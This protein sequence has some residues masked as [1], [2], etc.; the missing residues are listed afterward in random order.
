MSLKITD[1]ERTTLCVPFTPRCEKWN[2]REVWN[3]K[4]VEICRVETDAGFVGWGETL[5]HY[6]W[7]KVSDSSVD[8][9]LGKNPADFLGDD[10]LGAGLQM[11]LY[12]VVGKALGV[13]V[14]R[15]LN[16]PRVR[17]WCPISWWTIDFPPEALAEEAKDALAA[18]YVAYKTKA[19]PSFYCF[20][21]IDSLRP[22]SP[23]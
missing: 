18:G 17:E 2:A 1:V 14:Y 12:D 19:R 22:V 4:V 9:V 21:H 23:G 20:Q 7:G 5:P 8:K 10:S 16:L 11:A 3:W 6:T 13:P 15:L